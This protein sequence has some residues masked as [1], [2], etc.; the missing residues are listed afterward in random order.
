VKKAEPVARN[1]MDARDLERDMTKLTT[2]AIM[3]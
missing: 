1:A 3:P 2:A